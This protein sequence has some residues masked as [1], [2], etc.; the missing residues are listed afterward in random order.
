LT[1]TCAQPAP[2]PVG[3]QPGQLSRLQKVL[4]QAYN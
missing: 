2:L 1:S 4:L 3:L